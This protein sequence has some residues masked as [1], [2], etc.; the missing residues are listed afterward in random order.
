[1]NSTPMNET[2]VLAALRDIRDP[3]I[4][5]DIVELGLVYSV[6]IIDDWVGVK[7]TLTTPGCG[8]A[9]EIVESVRNRIRSI[10]GVSDGDVRLVVENIVGTFGFAAGDQPAADDDPAFCKRDLLSNL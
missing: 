3:E 1:M 7:M 9:G 5:A 6:T 4:P 10:P 8:L 2:T